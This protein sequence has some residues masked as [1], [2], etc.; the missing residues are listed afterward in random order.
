VRPRNAVGRTT[1]RAPGV[2][3]HHPGLILLGGGGA[4]DGRGQARDDEIVLPPFE[5]P[6]RFDA[7]R[8]RRPRFGGAGQRRHVVVRVRVLNDDLRRQQL[9]EVLVDARA[10]R[11]DHAD[12]ATNILTPRIVPRIVSSV[13]PRR[14]G[15]S[16][17]SALARAREQ[18]HER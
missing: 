8:S 14:P 15:G 4:R 10:S 13:R 12:V 7:V 5:E 9:L 11:V 18:A 17:W 2:G 6:D 1:R 16:S 3:E